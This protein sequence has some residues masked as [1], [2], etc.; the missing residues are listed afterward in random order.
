MLKD[1]FASVRIAA[2]KTLSNCIKGVK[3]VPTPDANVFPEYI[4]PS[5][6][7]LCNDK[8]EMVRSALAKHIAEVCST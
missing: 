6:V 3:M 2:L 4:L 5:I 8:N 7:P 1:E